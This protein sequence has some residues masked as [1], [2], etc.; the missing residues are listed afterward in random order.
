MPQ[1]TRRRDLEAHQE[2]WLVY[3]SDI[4]TGTIAQSVGNPNAAPQWQWRCGFYPGS[5][6]GEY[7]SGTAATFDQARADFGKAWPVFLAKR[8][9]A[10]FEAWRRKRAMTAWKYAMW[11]AGCRMPTQ[12]RE[13]QSRCFCGA[14][15]G[16]AYE[17]HVY[18]SHMEAACHTAIG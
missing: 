16:V 10:D 6:P 13:L 1:L 7:L 5:E 18:A 15:I 3:Y 17:E 14:E 12:V 4:H 9:E 2:T 11:D 8:T